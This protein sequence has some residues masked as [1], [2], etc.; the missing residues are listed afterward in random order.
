MENPFV[1][2]SA[3]I[4]EDIAVTKQWGGLENGFPDLR[5]TVYG[6]AKWKDIA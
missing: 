1:V 4:V 2:E 6:G 3:N 5:I